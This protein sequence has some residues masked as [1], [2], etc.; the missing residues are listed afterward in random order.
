VIGSTSLQFKSGDRRCCETYYEEDIQTAGSLTLLIQIALPCL[1]FKNLLVEN[2][3]AESSTIQLN[4]IGG[5]NVSTSPP[6]D[7]FIF[8]V[9]SYQ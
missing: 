4:L 7:H 5:T 6:I 1:V 3:K 2:F 9:V 8:F